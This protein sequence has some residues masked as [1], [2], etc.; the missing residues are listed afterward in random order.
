MRWPVPGALPIPSTWMGR[1]VPR[2]TRRSVA[3]LLAAAV[4]LAT[5]SA[6]G[7]NEFEDRT[8]TVDI[9]GRTTTFTLDSCGLDETTLFV[10]GRSSG[11]DVLQAVVGLDDD[12][13]TG[14][15]EST[16]LTVTDEG[17]DLA[18]FGPEAWDRRAGAGPV[19]GAITEASLRGARIQARGTLVSIDESVSGDPEL[20]DQELAFTLD[21]RCDD[22]DG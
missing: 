2:R 14:V 20:G 12:V 6:C 15:I 16:G 19:P 17:R 13:A 3:A 22:Q 9:A 7:G 10:V 11:G 21:A 8:A 4:A 18:A 1:L 5:L